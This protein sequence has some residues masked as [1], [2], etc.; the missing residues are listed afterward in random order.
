V[1]AAV[2]KA[3]RLATLGP[4]QN[5]ETT[6]YVIDLASNPASFTQMRA[7]S[8][9]TRRTS[10]LARDQAAAGGV[11]KESPCGTVRRPLRLPLPRLRSTARRRLRGRDRIGIADVESAA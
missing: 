10:S 2:G 7:T 1:A 5:H 3:E 4:P 9:R 11:P 6:L 8:R